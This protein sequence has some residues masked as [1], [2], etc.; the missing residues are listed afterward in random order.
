MDYRIRT[1]YL[2]ERVIDVLAKEECAD[3]VEIV[4]KAFKRGLSE[5]AKEHLERLGGDDDV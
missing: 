4:D 1:D 2:Y 5:L 3:P